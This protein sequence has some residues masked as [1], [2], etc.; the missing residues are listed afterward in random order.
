MLASAEMRAA[1]MQEVMT[2]RSAL[3]GRRPRVPQ[4][5]KLERV[6]MRRRDGI[7]RTLSQ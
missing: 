4:R 2:G 5:P 1:K 7:A 3:A 6:R